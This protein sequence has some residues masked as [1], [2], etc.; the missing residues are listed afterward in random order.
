MGGLV[1]V[2]SRSSNA[3]EPATRPLL[4]ETRPS[5]ILDR[6]LADPT[7]TKSIAKQLI[8]CARYES[9]L[10]RSLFLFQ[11]SP[12]L[13]IL[14]DLQVS[15]RLGPL[16]SEDSMETSTRWELILVSDVEKRRQAGEELKEASNWYPGSRRRPSVFIFHESP[17][18]SHRPYRR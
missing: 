13:T 18:K 12:T 7:L 17:G 1:E 6:G 16:E 15:Y 5:L 8:M 14:P 2:Y 11:A 9:I 3:A 4:T 10:E